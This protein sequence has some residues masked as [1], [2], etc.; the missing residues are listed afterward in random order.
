MTELTIRPTIIKGMG[1]STVN[2]QLLTVPVYVT[3]AISFLSLAIISDRYQIRSP[4]VFGCFCVFLIGYIILATADSVGARYASLFII[5]L[6]LYG[7][8]GTNVAW[9][10]GN[11]AGHFK[12][13][14]SMGMNQCI[15]NSAGAAIG[16]IYNANTSP[17]Y[18]MGL[19]I[20]IGLTGLGLILVAVNVSIL[21]EIVC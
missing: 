18:F 8:T 7:A 11:S 12:R 17:R 6:G 10:S 2:A 16:S 14:T 15:G 21:R 13:A 5:A 19:Y 3:G 20:S 1:Y 9:I 4:F